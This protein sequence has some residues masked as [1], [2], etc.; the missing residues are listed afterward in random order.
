MQGH[1]RLT[2]VLALCALAAGLGLAL[3][4]PTIY[5]A[6]ARLAVGG[7][8]GLAAESVP[9]YALAS[10]QLAANYARYVNDAQGQSVLGTDLGSRPGGVLKV[11]ASPI[12]ESN[13]VRVEVTSPVGSTA[14][15]AADAIATSLMRQV[16]DTSANS[17][18]ADET[19]SQF[20]AVSAKVAEAEQASDAAKAAVERA[21]SNPGADVSQLSQQAAAA[22]SQLAILGVQQEALGQK[23]RNQ[24]SSLSAGAANLVVVEKAS[25]TGDDRVSQLGQFG[26]GGLVAGFLLALGISVVLERRRGSGAVRGADGEVPI[27]EA[28]ARAVSSVRREDRSVP[29]ERVD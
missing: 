16:N 22:A 28:D 6:E 12:P 23:Y 14:R 10:Q 5:T 26:L 25:V 3:M 29:L 18:A 1:K 21:R 11:S 9:G 17:R 15:D 24:I 19:L 7:N 4:R 27:G 8:G 13:I 2:V 20:T